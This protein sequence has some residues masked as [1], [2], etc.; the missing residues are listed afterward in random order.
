MAHINLLPWRE[1][2]RKEK[3]QQFAVIGVGSAV[4]GGL[5]V[6]LTHM[7]M[8][9]LIDQQ[10]NRNKFLETEIASLDKKIA[11]IKDLEKT[12]TALL[13]RMDIIQQLQHSRP[14][15]V[16]LMDELVFTLPD[17]VFLNTI[18]QKGASLTMSGVAQSNAR[19]SAY[20]RNIDNSQWIGKP[21][22]DVIETKEDEKRRTATFVLRA[23]QIAPSEETTEGNS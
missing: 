22:L 8:N 9:G 6:L 14:Q 10:N 23:N 5:L 18:T 1:E 7:Q 15:S 4:V 21:R 17:G 12:K 19:V 20:M 16:H 11:R 13:A 3:Q 2:L